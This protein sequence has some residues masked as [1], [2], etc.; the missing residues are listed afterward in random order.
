M[1]SFRES[2]CESI[3]EDWIIAE[4]SDHCF[5]IQPYSWKNISFFEIFSKYLIIILVKIVIK[6]TLIWCYC[7]LT[8][9]SKGYYRS[10]WLSET[11]FM[12]NFDTITG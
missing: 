11:S 4:V 1:Y 8:K 2:K 6:K 10:N 5:F 9:G 3:L 7:F 12:Q